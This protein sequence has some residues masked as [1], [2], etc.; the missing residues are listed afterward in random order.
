MGTEYEDEPPLA[1]VLE[2]VRRKLV[3]RMAWSLGIMMIGLMTVLG[4]IV[5]KISAPSSRASSTE[6][7][8]KLEMPKGAEIVSTNIS[9]TGILIQLKLENGGT[10]LLVIDPSNG[11]LRSQFDLH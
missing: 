9:E 5:Y 11:V 1:P 2:N 8:V 7:P 3:R 4:A 6:E 10:R